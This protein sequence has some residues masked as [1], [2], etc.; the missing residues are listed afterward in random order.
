MLSLQYTQVLCELR[1]LPFC[2]KGHRQDIFSFLFPQLATFFPLFLALFPTPRAPSDSGSIS[3]FRFQQPSFF[4]IPGHHTPRRR[5]RESSGFVSCH[6]LLLISVRPSFRITVL[7]DPSD[8]FLLFVFSKPRKEV[9]RFPLLQIRHFSQLHEPRPL[10]PLRPAILSHGSPD[11]SLALQ[12]TKFALT[13]PR[14]RP[15]LPP[16]PG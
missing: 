3:Q 15:H 7:P 16:L 6:C 8:F 4:Q 9:T 1:P 2:Q 12:A 5:S 14:C 11:R 10:V 13:S